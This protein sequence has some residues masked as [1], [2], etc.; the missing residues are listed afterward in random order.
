MVNNIEYDRTYFS[1]F[2]HL[3]TYKARR[4][5]IAIGKTGNSRTLGIK[6]EKLPKVFTRLIDPTEHVNKNILVIGGGD[7]AVEA[8]IALAQ[9]NNDVAFSYRKETLSRPKPHNIKT[10]NS[11][12]TQNKITP[13]FNS[14]VKQIN[15]FSVIIDTPD[16]EGTIKNDIVYT[17][18]GTEIPIQFFKRSHIKMEGEKNAHWW[19]NFITMFSFFS[20]LYFGKSGVAINI[21]SAHNT[22]TNKFLAYLSAPYNIKTS[23]SLNNYEW[24][25]SLEFLL[26]WLGSVIF[27]ITGLL[28]LIL[29]I[30]KRKVYFSTVWL[31]I[32][33]TYIIAAALLF[34]VIYFSYNLSKNSGWAEEP[35]YWYSLL[36]C[37]TMLLFGIRRIWTKPTRYIVYQTITLLMVQI[38]FLFLL[39]FHLYDSTLAQWF[40]AESYMIRE[41]FPHG[42]WSAFAFILFWPL[43]LG[44]FG[45][46]TFWTWFP[47]VQTFVILPIIIM[48]WGKGS[49]C[50]WIC[51]CGGM[52]ETFGD[53]YRTK[54]PHGILPKKMENL[55][56]IILWIVMAATLL[57]YLYQNN[58]ITNGMLADTLWGLYK[59]S[60]DVIFA[61]VVGL[62]CYFFY[63][64]RIWCRFGC[65]LAALMHIYTRFSLYRILSDKKRCISCNICTKVC[66]MG[67][68]V[69]NYANKGIP[70]NDVECVRCSACVV[71]C[72]MRVLSFGKVSEVDPNN[73]FFKKMTIP[74][75]KS[76]KS[77]LPSE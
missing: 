31:K 21:F 3:E 53:E 25:G 29:V 50:G 42:K 6:S 11:L 56:Q 41:I 16:G 61:G 64:G 75:E 23:W 44:A 32:K 13:I 10:F 30:H 19:L 14:T 27:I 49:Y 52:A 54:S 73:T 22:I 76:W 24:L 5:I 17:L 47:L 34:I 7:S 35:T 74:I 39:P 70:M 69:M 63:G 71:Y 12:V 38:F 58:M 36:Y 8:A 66:H 48:Y 1:V 37:S 26:G 77:G 51:S 40:N 33:S 72:P 43:N 15:D 55:G 46:S 18:I 20:M 2:T 65:P 67:I 45:S 68:D 57:R 60:I 4:V 59:F 9:N 28:S 62:G